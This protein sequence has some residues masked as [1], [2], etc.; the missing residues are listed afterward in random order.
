MKNQINITISY[1]PEKV[2]KLYDMFFD[3]NDIGIVIRF[4]L[5]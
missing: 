5:N 3:R 2:Y 4:Y 1:D